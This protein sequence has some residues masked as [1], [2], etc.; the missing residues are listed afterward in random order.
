VLI[1]PDSDIE[2][3]ELQNF[4]LASKLFSDGTGGVHSVETSLWPTEPVSVS[5]VAPSLAL[6][7]GQKPGDAASQR[8][9]LDGVDHLS[10][11]TPEN[12]ARLAQHDG[13]SLESE[14]AV[15]RGLQW[16]AAHQNPNGSWS[17]D[18]F[19]QTDGCQGRCRN[20]G[21][22]SDTAATALALLPFLGAGETHHRGA[23]K[24]VVRRGLYW[25]VRAQRDDGD[26][27]GLGHGRMYAHAL[28]AIVL[29]EAFALTRDEALH[30]PARRAIDFIVRAQ[31]EKGGWRYEPGQPGDLSIVGWQLMALRSAQM[32]YLPIPKEVLER[33][34]QFVESCRTD[35]YG[36]TYAYQ[37]FP[38][39]L[40][41]TNDTKKI[42]RATRHSLTAEALLC[43]QYSGWRQDHPAL[44]A[45]A[46]WLLQSH[47]PSEKEPNFYYWYY[48]TQAMHHLGGPAWQAWNSQMRDLL[49]K[50]QE[51][52]G[53]ESGSWTPRSRGF[54][55]QENVGGRL[56]VTSL[57]ICTL[58]V[59]YRHLPLYRRVAVND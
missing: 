3:A 2:D 19:H 5:V 51:R 27:R 1:S 37:L 34:H 25:L 57:A 44:V 29:C 48:A 22:R 38:V 59:Y 35:R 11:R 21:H 14:A 41:E 31:H 32:V 28:S 17:L 47:P 54:P 45:G 39:R 26:L 23:Y 56:Y 55:S 50:M 36:S 24:N 53:H 7:T 6:R 16:L 18:G 15:E 33:A 9:G 40:V 43:R 49:I 20:P 10:G 4:P 12:R 58:E 46:R 52:E 30:L 42:E 13:G 8:S